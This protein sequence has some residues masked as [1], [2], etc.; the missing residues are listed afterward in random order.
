MESISITPASK[1]YKLNKNAKKAFEYFA[2]KHYKLAYGIFAENL[3]ED[4]NH[5]ESKIGLL[6]S[7][8]AMDFESQANGL[9]EFYQALKKQNISK[10]KA[11]R[12]M[13]D[14]IAKFDNSTD[15]IFAMIKGINNVKADEIDGILYEDFK[16]IVQGG[17]EF[18]KTFEDVMFNTRLIFL[19][20]YEFYDFLNYLV[21]NGYRETFID[22][23]DG[24]YKNLAHDKH[25]E[26][27]LHKAIYA[28][29]KKHKS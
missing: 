8:M 2:N 7:D 18:S 3:S 9:Y 26:I 20:K 25:I 5:L 13:L 27:I 28:D 15:G 22:Y 23:L 21:E 11:Q 24:F 1:R 10:Q 29:N 16:K 19:N 14:T 6:L 4:A 12:Q 17:K